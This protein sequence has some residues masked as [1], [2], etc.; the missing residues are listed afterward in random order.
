MICLPLNILETLHLQ[1]L[2]EKLGEIET[3]IF[4]S[5]NTIQP[6][7]ILNSIDY[8]SKREPQT[9]FHLDNN[10][11][12]GHLLVHSVNKTHV[13]IVSVELIW[14]LFLNIGVLSFKYVSTPNKC[15]RFT[16]FRRSYVNRP[17]D[18]LT[19]QC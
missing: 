13:L 2:S 9:F 6:P 17:V 3:Y 8:S 5:I 15:L 4:I 7:H 18:V 1:H 14:L 11:V 12:L 10:P 19:N 16:R